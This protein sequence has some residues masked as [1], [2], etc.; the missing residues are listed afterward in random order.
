MRRCIKKSKYLRFQKFK[1]I[2]WICSYINIPTSITL[3]SN[4][5][6]QRTSS[7]IPQL[8]N[9]PAE[10]FKQ[11]LLQNPPS[12]PPKSTCQFQNT[13]PSSPG[14]RS[15]LKSATSPLPA[16]IK[17]RSVM[18]NFRDTL[19]GKSFHARRRALT[20]IERG[21]LSRGGLARG[22]DT[23]RVS[24]AFPPACVCV[25]RE[26]RDTVHVLSDVCV[27][28]ADTRCWNLRCIC[29]TGG[30]FKMFAF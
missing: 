16:N 9:F 15:T 7:S 21:H 5:V 19:I 6:S 11:N 29:G 3:F 1:V 13:T 28:R 4:L 30:T 14:T 24:W 18:A 8:S 12:R 20:Y 2:R 27:S 10:N 17:L 26:T 22:R 25:W 23:Y